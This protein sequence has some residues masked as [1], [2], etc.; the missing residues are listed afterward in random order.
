MR[1]TFLLSIAAA[2]VLAAPVLAQSG[3]YTWTGYARSKSDSPNCAVAKMKIDVTVTGTEVKGLF[4]QQ[5]RTQ[6]NFQATADAAGSFRTKAQVGGGGIMDVKG[7]INNTTATVTL[8]GYCRWDAKL[9][10]Q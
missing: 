3:N 2:T 8:D 5:G 10:K 6:R 1:P 7:T 4:Q 9:T